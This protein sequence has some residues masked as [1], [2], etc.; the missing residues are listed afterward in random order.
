MAVKLENFLKLE[1]EFVSGTL[2]RAEARE[3]G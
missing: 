3:S 1:N 2:P